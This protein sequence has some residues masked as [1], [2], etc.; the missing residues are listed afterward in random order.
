LIDLLPDIHVNRHSSLP[1]PALFAVAVAAFAAGGCRGDAD[2]GGKSTRPVSVRMAVAVEKSAPV[3]VRAVGRIVSN[4]SV[5]LRPQVSGL[6]VAARFTEGQRVSEGQVLLEIDP[7]PYAAALAEA[8]GRRD[9]ERAR[10][11]NSKAETARLA[12]LAGKELIGRQEFETAKATA[13]ASAAGAEAAEA[14]VQRAELNLAWCTLR[15]PISGRT[16]RL[17]VHPGNLVSAGGAEPIVT[18]EQTRPVFAS[19]SIPER[20]LSLLRPRGKAQAVQVRTSGGTETAGT[21]DFID[22]AVDTA[23]GTILLKARIP[24]EDEALLPGQIVDVT[25]AL[26]DRAKAVVVPAAA[27]S[28]GQQG[29][30]VFVVKGD[31][32][33]ELRPVTVDQVLGDE[34][35]IGRGVAAGETVVTEGQLK[36]VPGAKVEPAERA[37]EGK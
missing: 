9:Q 36:L 37:P 32:S 21:V 26:A 27:V 4:R 28:Q 29:E 7:R 16:G 22:N 14:A 12:E 35:V 6:L 30:Y 8:R 31:R 1:L 13:A 18:I 5:A 11:D 25:V 19:F 3:E 34:A 20:H 23:T 2:G 15:A 10:A 17:L 33:V 24:N